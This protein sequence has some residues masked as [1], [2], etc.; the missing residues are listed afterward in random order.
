MKRI[1]IALKQGT[2]L[3]ALRMID[4]LV[5][6]FLALIQTEN[7]WQERGLGQPSQ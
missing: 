1:N 4:R 3:V 2:D 7:G 6:L 5:R